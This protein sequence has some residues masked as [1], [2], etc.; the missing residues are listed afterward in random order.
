METS[1]PQD[2][3]TVEEAALYMKS[4]KQTLDFYR[5]KGVGPAYIKFRKR[6]FYLKKDLDDYIQNHRITPEN[7]NQ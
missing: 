7:N 4:K 5:H 6:V 2:R 1:T 3:L